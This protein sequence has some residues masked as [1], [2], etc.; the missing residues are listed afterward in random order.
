M[1]ADSSD[2]GPESPEEMDLRRHIRE[3]IA[4]LP[5]AGRASSANG[6]AIPGGTG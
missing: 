3:A 6:G 5:F 4:A 2:Q 1:S